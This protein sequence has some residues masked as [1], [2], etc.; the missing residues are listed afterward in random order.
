MDAL[1]CIHTRRSIREYR[2][3]PVGDD[4]VRQILGAA[5]MA[6]SAGNVRT[7]RSSRRPPASTPTA[8]CASTRRCRSS[9]AAT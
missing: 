9:S 2:D 7:R 4:L 6:P 5:M 8:T 1:E 3:Q